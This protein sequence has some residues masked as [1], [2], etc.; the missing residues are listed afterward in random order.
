MVQN[1]FLQEYYQNYLVFIPAIE[2]IKYFT[3]TIEIE[4]KKSNG[5]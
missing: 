3:G 1:I 4:S 2:C 5:M